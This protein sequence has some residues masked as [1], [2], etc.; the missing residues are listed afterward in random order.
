MFQSS[1]VN[2][3]GSYEISLG[4]KMR[5]LFL[6]LPDPPGVYVYKDYCG[7]FGSAFPFRKNQ[8]HITFPPL[9]DA[10]AASIVEMKG[11]EVSIVDA[12]VKRDSD[13][14]LL[15][16]LK[17]INPEIIISRISLPSFR[18]NLKIISKIK[19]H[20]P[21]VIYVGWGSLCKVLPEIVLL[22]GDLDIVVRDELEFTI[23]SLIKTLSSNG[24]L[25]DVEGIS[26]KSPKII[27]NP[28][29]SS[30]KNLN[31]LPLPAYHLL[32]MKKYQARESYFL[33]EGSENKTVNFFTLLSSRGCNFNCPYCPYP[34]IFGRWRAMSPK[35]VV[36]EM[37]YLVKNYNI[38]TF[39][40][41]DQVFT[42][43]PKRVEKICKEIVDRKLEV[44]WACETHVKKLSQHLIRT[45]K[46]AGCTRIQVGVETGDPQLLS[47]I[48]KKGCTVNDIEEVIYHLHEEGVLIEA[49]FIVG[50]PGENWKTI[51]NTAKIIRRTKPDDVAIS[52]ITPYPG[53]KLFSLAK[54]RNWLITE[55]WS[56]YTTS[57][58][59]MAL[60][61]FSGED[62]K[63]AQRYLYGIFLYTS[64]LNRLIATAKRHRL[65][66]FC[67]TFVKELPQIGMG[68]YFITKFII[69]SK[70]R[71]IGGN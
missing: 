43:I 54:N 55:D 46:R 45:M 19:N 67:Q 35:K 52:I 51:K 16:N 25:K 3:Q 20:F 13:K 34:V 18:N 12:Q 9:F 39:W 59:V 5:I 65:L 40:F 1:Y 69:K 21:N 57:Q 22:K 62:M 61:N 4:E 68:I 66:K 30:E 60:P 23:F 70:V 47:T 24:N 6:N 63:E 56:K 10:Y 31:A 71:S 2:F 36:D 26:F 53:T 15:Q 49:N 48:G 44:T 8:K 17:R 28:Y 58:P 14:L 41:H 27:H 29:V 50:L 37:E 42:M 38:R 32:D 11:H 64:R 7:G 33:K